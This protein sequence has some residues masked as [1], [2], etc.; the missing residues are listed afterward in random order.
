[1]IVIVRWAD[2]AVPSASRSHWASHGDELARVLAAIYHSKINRS[3]LFAYRQGK[4]FGWGE[5]P[6]SRTPSP[7]TGFG[8]SALTWVPVLAA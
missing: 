8:G 3:P 2:F 1:M 4:L 6:P 5:S 7:D